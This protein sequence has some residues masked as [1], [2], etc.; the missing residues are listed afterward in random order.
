MHMAKIFSKKAHTAFGRESVRGPLKAHIFLE[1]LS[2]ALVA[3]Y[4]PQKGKFVC[5]KVIFSSEEHVYSAYFCWT[6]QSVVKP[7]RAKMDTVVIIKGEQLL[8]SYT[9][10]CGLMSHYFE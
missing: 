2:L 10:A 8:H 7:E 6:T 3:G 1:Q 5:K 9:L 4:F